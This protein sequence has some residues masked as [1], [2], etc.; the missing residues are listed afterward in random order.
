MADD[1]QATLHGRHVTFFDEMPL[2]KL[3][4]LGQS[5]AELAQEVAR[6]TVQRFSTKTLRAALFPQHLGTMAQPDG[7]ARAHG[8]CGDLMTFYLLIKDE[9]IQKITFTTDGCDATIASGEMLASMVSGL[10]LDEAAQV[11]PN[12]LLEALDGLPPNHVHCAEL[13]VRTLREAIENYRGARN[14]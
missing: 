13:A 5:Q 11:A 12:D 3:G 2:E 6:R 9:R 1:E 4:M 8:E 10:I 14:A 7:Y